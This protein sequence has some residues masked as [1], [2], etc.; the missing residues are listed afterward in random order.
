[1]PF[2]VEHE[3]FLLRMIGTTCMFAVLQVKHIIS[4]RLIPKANQGRQWHPH[5]TD[6]NTGVQ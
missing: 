3:Y 2:S 5:F 6:E 1:M 4:S